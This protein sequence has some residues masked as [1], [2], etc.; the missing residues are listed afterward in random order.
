M[1]LLG[2]IKLRCILRAFLGAMF[3]TTATTVEKTSATQPNQ[4]LLP[5]PLVPAGTNVPPRPHVV[6][7]SSRT[8]VVNE[9]AVITDWFRLIGQE[10]G[11]LPSDLTDESIFPELGADSLTSLV[12]AEKL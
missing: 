6:E 7:S 11:Y 3:T 2:E 12:L 9:P 8:I 5:K 10:T 1:G 4:A